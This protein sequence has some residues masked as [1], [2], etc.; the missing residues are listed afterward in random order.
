M[1]MC[2]HACACLCVYIQ[3]IPPTQQNAF[4]SMEG[5]VF[6]VLCKTKVVYERLYKTLQLEILFKSLLK[7]VASVNYF[8]PRMNCYCVKHMLKNSLP[9]YSKLLCAR[10]DLNG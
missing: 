10:G 9:G 7:Y 3:V 6:F 2:V 4:R 8:H 1:Y 5:F